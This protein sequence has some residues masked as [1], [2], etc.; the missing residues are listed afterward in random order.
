MKSILNNAIITILLLAV[1]SCSNDFL[2]EHLDK[3]AV[4]AGESTIYISPEWESAD[5][6]LYLP[7]MGNA[8]F[9]IEKNPSWLQISS[10]TGSLVNSVANIHCSAVRMSGF[11]NIGIYLDKIEVSADKQSFYVPVAY[12]TEGNPKIQVERKITLNAGVGYLNIEIYN[13]G[14]GILLWDV[15]SLPDWLGVDMDRF[16]YINSTGT[17]IAQNSCANLPLVIN[18]D[19]I[20]GEDLKGRIL[21][22]TNDKNNR[23][24]EIEVELTI[25]N[26]EISIWLYNNKIDFGATAT[27]YALDIDA[28]G[29]GMLVWHFEGLPEWLSV[30]P[31][32]GIYNTHIYYEDV[33]FTCDRT[34]LQPGINSAIIYLK[35][36]AY[37]KP[38]I[39]IMVTARAPGSNANIYNL[40]GNIVDAAFDKNTNT[41]Y[42]VTS[43]PNKFI[44][45]NATN[46]TVLYELQLGKA[47]TCLTI[48]EDNTKAAVGHGGQISV[49]NL[50]NK[51]VA[52]SFEVNGTLFDIGW[53][54]D[55]W[56]C[57][58]IANYRN[59]CWVN[60][61][62]LATYK[63]TDSNLY[64]NDIIKKIP[65]HPYIIATRGQTSPSGFMVYSASTKKLKSYAHMSLSNFWF[66]EDGQYIF[67]LNKDVYRTANVINS[68]DTFNS[69]FHSIGRFNG[70]PADDYYYLPKWMEHSSSTHAVWIL[71]SS[72]STIFKYDDNDFSYQKTY[73]YS[74]LY[75]PNGQSAYEVE[76]QY[77]FSNKEGTELLVLCK[78]KSN[79]N[80]SLE[81]IGVTF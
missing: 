78:G 76:G 35:S 54:I 69:D 58:S 63:T 8:D 57:Y 39:E 70:E 48:S 5:Y 20:S 68:D 15:V 6:Q 23:V 56:V 41:L 10:M 71:N 34:K 53:G 21:L 33:I 51:S 45:Y 11:D 44:A 80:W 26:P 22:K 30:T 18:L 75:Q 59:L 77:L 13:Q 19:E 79:N 17:I 2:N 32:K 7:N 47:P 72:Q 66:S 61:S 55:D 43:T 50:E 46:R 62:D 49:V 14:E 4:P 73:F 24:V 64:N 9:K 42:Y 28:W 37:N 3:P 81:F 29:T 38:S 1:V 12:I 27:S 52:K 67:G 25:G 36:N 74:D 31:S 40:A 60:T 16:N 65:G